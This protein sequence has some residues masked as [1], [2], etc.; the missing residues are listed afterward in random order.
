MTLTP[1]GSGT[2]K[3]KFAPDLYTDDFIAYMKQ[4]HDKLRA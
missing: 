3:S 4:F 1:Q 2:R